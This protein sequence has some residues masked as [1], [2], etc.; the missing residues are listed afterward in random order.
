MNCNGHQLLTLDL[1]L[2]S[3]IPLIMKKML[4]ISKGIPIA[5]PAPQS[6]VHRK[7]FS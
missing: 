2:F 1:N 5:I 7:K 3:L 6:L 4:R